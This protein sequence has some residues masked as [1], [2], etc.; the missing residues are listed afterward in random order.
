THHQKLARRALDR[1]DDRR[2]RVRTMIGQLGAAL[3]AGNIDLAFELHGELAKYHEAIA[4]DLKIQEGHHG[5]ARRY[6]QLAMTV[7]RRFRD[8][9][10]ETLGESEQSAPTRQS[11]MR[12]NQ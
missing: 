5:R 8:S 1:F 7:L 4:L 10:R 6:A 3:A 12:S 2:E 9:I 11:E